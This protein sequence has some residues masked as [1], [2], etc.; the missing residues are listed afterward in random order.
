MI[1]V[2]DALTELAKVCLHLLPPI[3]D[4]VTIREGGYD[5]LFNEHSKWH[6]NQTIVTTQVIDHMI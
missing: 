2:I 4:H 6:E 3:S 1:K 5:C